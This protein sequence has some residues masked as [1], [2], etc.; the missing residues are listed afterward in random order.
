MDSKLFQAL[1]QN[2]FA[3]EQPGWKAVRVRPVGW[4]VLVGEL[5]FEGAVGNGEGGGGQ[6]DVRV[7]DV[8]E[9]VGGVE[10]VPC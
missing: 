7:G 6:P 8:A 4:V 10:E 9:F 3:G 2:L 5:E 1:D